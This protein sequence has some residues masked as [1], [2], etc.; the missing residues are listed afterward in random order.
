M[1]ED[2]DVVLPELLLLLAPLDELLL[3]PA[4]KT[5]LPIAAVAAIAYFPRKVFPPVPRPYVGRKPSI[6]ARSS[7]SWLDKLTGR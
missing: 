6:L 3:H 5:R 4:A 2:T 7:T 1:A